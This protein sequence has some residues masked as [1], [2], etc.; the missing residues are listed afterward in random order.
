MMSSMVYVLGF[1]MMYWGFFSFSQ[2]FY[3]S[4]QIDFIFCSSVLYYIIIRVH[5]GFSLVENCDLLE[6]TRTLTPF[7]RQANH[8]NFRIALFCVDY[9]HL[10]WRVKSFRRTKKLILAKFFTF[11]LYKTN[12]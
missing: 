9:D 5:S 1:E 2:L 8:S 7:Q 3:C 6:D 4:K 11:L 12:R 10:K